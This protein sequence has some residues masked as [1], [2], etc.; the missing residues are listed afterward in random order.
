[1][2]QL[3]RGISS[4]PSHRERTLSLK[5][6][7]LVTLRYGHYPCSRVSFEMR[8]SLTKD[9]EIW[10]M[11]VVGFFACALLLCLNHGLHGLGDCTD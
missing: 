4:M 5:E 6:M 2:L 10:G 9:R 8:I 3:V 7:P 11:G 1:M